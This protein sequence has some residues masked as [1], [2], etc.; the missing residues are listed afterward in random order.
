MVFL[1]VGMLVGVVQAVDFAGI[2]GLFK[3]YRCFEC[4]DKGGLK[5]RVPL[6][7]YSQLIRLEIVVPKRPEESTLYLSITAEEGSKPMPPPN[8][9]YSAIKGEDLSTIEKW[10][11]E[12]APQ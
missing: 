10:I 4:H 1:V 2:Q 6:D 7:N 12:G 9:G 3:K 5:K 11:L 8:K